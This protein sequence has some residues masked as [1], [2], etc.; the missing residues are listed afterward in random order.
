MI[1]SR[2]LAV[3][4]LTSCSPLPD[5]KVTKTLPVSPPNGWRKYDAIP[6]FSVI[7]ARRLRGPGWCKPDIADYCLTIP[8]ARMT[9]P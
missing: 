7:S 9:F 2:V 1:V 3:L 6:T 5:V 8:A 4:L